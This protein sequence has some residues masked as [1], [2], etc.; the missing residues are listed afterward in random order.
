MT[1]CY[2]DYSNEEKTTMT[3][4]ECCT[5]DNGD[6]L[7]MTGIAAYNAMYESQDFQRNK[8][9]LYQDIIRIGLGQLVAVEEV[10][11][12]ANVVLA[13]FDARFNPTNE[14]NA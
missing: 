8:F 3:V 13:D 14:N 4:G 9:Y 5:P 11:H 2:D 10:V 1:K 6:G 12:A 7:P